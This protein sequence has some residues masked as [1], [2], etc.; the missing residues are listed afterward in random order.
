M[1]EVTDFVRQEI[2]AVYHEYIGINVWIAVG[3][4]LFPLII[5]RIRKKKWT[6]FKKRWPYFLGGYLL[7]LYFCYLVE[8]TML[9]REPGSRIGTKLTLF[10]TYGAGDARSIAFMVENILMFVPL[11]L[12]I[13]MI[14]PV[15]RKWYVLIPGGFLFSMVIECTQLITQRGYFET[16]DIV[17]N[18]IGGIV[19]YV[20]YLLVML[21]WKHRRSIVAFIPAMMVMVMIFGFS[22]DE[23]EES[24]SLSLRVTEIVVTCAENLLPQSVTEDWVHEEKV[25][26]WHVLVR[27]AAHMTEYALL[28]ITLFLGFGW[29]KVQDKRRIL[30]ALII[31]FVYACIDEIHQRFIPGRSGNILDVL[32]DTSGGILA[33]IVPMIRLQVAKRRK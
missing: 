8:I 24:A 17:L 20:L 10:A 12:L 15:F 4:L 28:T 14:I 29:N 32:I 16:D 22:G 18:G 1:E 19:G 31:C 30:Y 2:L 23:G 13:P 5:L 9:C 7:V 27:K 6:F 25:Q 33:M 21:A 3:I 11:G 26:D